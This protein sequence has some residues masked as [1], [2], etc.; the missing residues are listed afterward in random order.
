MMNKEKKHSYIKEM[1]TQFDKSEAVIV[2]LYQGLTVNQLD[3][4]RAKIRST[5]SRPYFVLS[6]N[7]LLTLRTKLP[8]APSVR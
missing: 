4:L 5:T 2:A 1:T 8:Q 3:H 7:F 6:V